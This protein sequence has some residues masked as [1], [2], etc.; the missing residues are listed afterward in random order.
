MQSRAHHPAIK[1]D[2]RYTHTQNKNN[3]NNNNNKL[4]FFKLKN[5]TKQNKKKRSMHNGSSRQTPSI[6]TAF[7]SFENMLLDIYKAVI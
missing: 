2:Q 1:K 5:K 7:K 3:N 6:M 4:L